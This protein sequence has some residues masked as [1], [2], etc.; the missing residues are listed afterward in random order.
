MATW[1]RTV[2][3]SGGYLVCGMMGNGT[4]NPAPVPGKGDRTDSAADITVY[5]EDRTGGGA[6]I[7]YHPSGCTLTG[8]TAKA[9]QT[10]PPST[11]TGINL[12]ITDTGATGAEY[13]YYVDGKD[14][15]GND[16]STEDPQIHNAT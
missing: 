4:S 5:S 8:L 14:S 2:T 9:N 11:I 13:E 12:T 7:I 6:K 10:A 16:L 1:N 3:V 15:E